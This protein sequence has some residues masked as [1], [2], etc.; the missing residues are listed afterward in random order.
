VLGSC[1]SGNESPDSINGRKCIFWLS[2]YWLLRKDPAQLDYMSMCIRCKLP[3]PANQTV[4]FG[5]YKNMTHCLWDALGGKQA[6]QTN[7]KK[8]SQQTARKLNTK[9]P[10]GESKE[11]KSDTKPVM[12]GYS[13]SPNTRDL[14]QELFEQ[15]IVRSAG[16]VR[17]DSM[18]PRG[19][20]WC[21]PEPISYIHNLPL[22]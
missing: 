3:S 11:F 16:H 6:V 15:L 2:N 5:R 19:P 9:A 13:P 7:I 8:I 12:S 22:L 21:S 4:L 14:L 10:T 1:E 18:Q 17:H 20:M